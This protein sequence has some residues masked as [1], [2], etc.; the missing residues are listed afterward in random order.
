MRHL[1]VLLLLSGCAQRYLLVTAASALNCPS[2]LVNVK[3]R[4][5]DYRAEGCGRWA[6][7]N[8]LWAS[9]PDEWTC[10]ARGPVEK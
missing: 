7:C 4:Q 1:I 5:D 10:E 8:R 3:E 6:T 2:G 9:G